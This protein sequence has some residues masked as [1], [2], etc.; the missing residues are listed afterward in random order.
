MR[1]AAWEFGSGSVRIPLLG[2]G[3]RRRSL[4][5]RANCTTATTRRQRGEGAHGTPDEC[6]LVVAC[7]RTLRATAFC[8]W[9]KLG[10]LEQLRRFYHPTVWASVMKFVAH[11]YPNHARIGVVRA[12]KRIAVVELIGGIA[13]VRAHQPHSGVLAEGLAHRQIEGVDSSADG[14]GRLRSGIPSHS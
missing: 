4:P 5:R 14:S 7:G 3:G 13:N 12:S 2:L 6:E 11:L 1:L 9:R 8:S 10:A